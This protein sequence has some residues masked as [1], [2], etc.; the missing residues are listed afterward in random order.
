MLMT[1]ESSDCPFGC[2]LEEE[3][4]EELAQH[5]FYKHDEEDV[6]NKLAELVSKIKEI[7]EWGHIHGYRTKDQIIQDL[8]NL[9]KEKEKPEE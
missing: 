7:I 6:A 9:I 4:Q 2:K 8:K 3:K 5:L 1:F